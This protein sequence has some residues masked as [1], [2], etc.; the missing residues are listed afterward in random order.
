MYGVKSLLLGSK[1]RI[2]ATVVVTLGIAIGGAFGAGLLGAPGVTG[3]QNSFGDVTNET[4]LIHTNLTVENPNPFGLK[5]GG[6]IVSY[7]VA[8]NDVTMANG[9]KDGVALNSGRSDVHFESRMDNEKMPR[10]WVSHIRNGERTTVRVD[11]T[12]TSSTLGRTFAAPPVTRQVETDIISQ[13][14]STETRPMNA[15]V[16]VVSNPLAY[17]NETSARWGEVTRSETPID[18][19]FVVFNPKTTPLALTEI[20]YNITMNGVAVGEGATTREHIVEGGT[21]ETIEAQTVIRNRRLDDWWV[22]HLKNDQVTELRIEFYAKV[23]VAGETYRI[24]L[25]EMTYTK[26]IETDIFGTKN[27]TAA[28]GGASVGDTTTDDGTDSG[29]SAPDGTTESAG[30]TA[31]DDSG[32]GS[33]TTTTASG[34]TGGDTTESGSASGGTTDGGSGTTTDDGLL[35]VERPQFA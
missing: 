16:P 6:V 21:T 30:T 19:R 31:S 12:A 27:Q 25:R 2:L 34:G 32:A 1:I 33:G 26:T 23:R 22:T 4:T 13:F 11:A 18:M 3:V 15:S 5:L 24:Q 8:M 17:V 20:G 29:T 14:N 28:S 7:D 9:T 35:A 10:W